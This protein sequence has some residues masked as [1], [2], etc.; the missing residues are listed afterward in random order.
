LRTG[1][2]ECPLAFLAGNA[3]RHDAAGARRRGLPGL[4]RQGVD[5]HLTVARPRSD[6]ALHVFAFDG[7]KR[8][9]ELRGV[10]TRFVDQ[11][12]ERLG[13]AQTA[14]TVGGKGHAPGL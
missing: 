3:E 13:G 9:E 11:A 1:N 4:A 10:Q 2:L 5:R 12:P 8:Q 7:E 6:V 14:R